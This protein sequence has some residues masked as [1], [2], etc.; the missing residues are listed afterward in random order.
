MSEEKC[1]NLNEEEDIRMEDSTEE[2][3][4]DVADDGDNKKKINALRWEVYFQ[5]KHELIKREFFVSAPNMKGG[6]IVWTNV[7][8]NITKEKE[9]YEAI[10]LR[11]FDYELSGEE[12]GGGV[13][14]GLG[15]Y[16]YLKHLIKL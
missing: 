10:G 12:K 11:G 4:R 16:H 15:R 1:M 14:E 9:D 2:H 7:K 6:N 8:D 13:R 3:R 5:E